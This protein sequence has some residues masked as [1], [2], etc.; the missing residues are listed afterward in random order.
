MP[1]DFI[2]DDFLN[3]KINNF[4][5]SEFPSIFDEISSYY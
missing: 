3:L 4:N 5:Q 1:N 2:N